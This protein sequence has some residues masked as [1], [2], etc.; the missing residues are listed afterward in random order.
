MQMGHRST[1]RWLSSTASVYGLRLGETR[2]AGAYKMST[3]TERQVAPVQ[4][5]ANA[6][7]DKPWF[8]YQNQ[9]GPQQR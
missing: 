3:S 6:E 7:P 9:R 2:G 4:T 5:H 1:A 8:E